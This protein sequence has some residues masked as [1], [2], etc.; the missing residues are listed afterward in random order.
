MTS[1]SAFGLFAVTAM[2]VC[3]VL[4]ERS[5]WFIL[6]IVAG[7]RMEGYAIRVS[8]SARADSQALWPR[9]EC[10]ERP[11]LRCTRG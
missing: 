10:I 4:D 9:R 8:R 7:P 6:A 1:L 2:L 3:Y 5:R 11:W